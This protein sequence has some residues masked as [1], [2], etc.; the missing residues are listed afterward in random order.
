MRSLQSLVMKTTTDA[1]RTDLFA[2]TERAGWRLVFL[3]RS[4]A[5]GIAVLFYAVTEDWGPP[6]YYIL[7]VLS[8][9]FALGVVELRSARSNRAPWWL[10]YLVAAAIIGLLAWVIS[11]P[12]P[13]REFSY[14]PAYYLREAEFE[15]LL[16]AIAL[17]ALTL[18]PAMVIWC[19]SATIASWGAITIWVLT[20][21]GTMSLLN[22]DLGA[23]LPR[24][25]R[26]AITLDP[27]VVNIVGEAGHLVVAA[28][29]A[30]IV[31]AA[32]WRS[33]RLARDYAQAEHDRTSLARYFSPNMVDELAHIENPFG[34]VRRQEIG[35]LFVDIVGF[36]TYS[37]A[38]APEQVIDL[39]REF[40]RR[41]ADIV[42][43]NGGTVD[44]YIGD[45]LMATFGVPRATGREAAVALHCARDMLDS[46]R[47]WNQAR[48]PAGEA[49]IDAR[50]GL[51]FG[52]VVMGTIGSERALSFA[53]IGD[54]PNV[55]N[56]LQR[57]TRS[58][59]AAIAISQ[60]VIEVAHLQPGVDERELLGFVDRG[61]QEIRG[62]EHTVH[63][64][65]L[66]ATA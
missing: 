29:T 40:H 48:I 55:A 14:P 53:V 18:S 9:L 59:D 23:H 52:P 47:D 50:I 44:N 43:A 62:R 56:R 30:G 27:N 31:A 64:W 38:H 39:L 26:L 63:V 58:L 61:E 5:I 3:A 22:S 42:F 34:P 4:V 37:E 41:M 6:L 10:K 12:N 7:G 8:L 28:V 15:Y 66:A 13:F 1:R 60:D 65:T 49:P 21:P 35:V 11:Q 57:L 20:R 36:T 33:R 51:H 19:G 45:C 24:H 2:A 25:Q 17:A 16:V 32:V 46:L 54:T